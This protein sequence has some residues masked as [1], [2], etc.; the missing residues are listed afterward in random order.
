[1]R[2]SYFLLQF[3]ILKKFNKKEMKIIENKEDST[4]IN[5]VVLF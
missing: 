3:K 4:P 1:M 5:I 2:S